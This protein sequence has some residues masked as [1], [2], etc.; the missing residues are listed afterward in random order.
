MEAGERQSAGAYAGFEGAVAG[1]TLPDVIQLNGHARFSG[2]ITVEDGSRTGAIFFRDGDIIHAEQGDAVGELAFYRIIEWPGGR[3]SLKPKVTTT[4]HTVR[5]SL[6]Y[7]LL[8]AHRLMDERRQEGG[9]VA[10]H[11][12]GT[13]RDAGE[14]GQM[15]GIPAR[16][17][18]IAGID[19][20]VV[21]GGDGS[22]VADSSFAAERLAAQALY[23]GMVGSRL[24]RAFGMGDIRSAAV[25]GREQHLLVYASRGHYLSIAVRGT[26]AIGG[27]EA[28]VRQALAPKSQE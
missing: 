3:F 7:L 17:R 9:A 11:S 5:Q 8:E 15:G 14:G 18:G 10:G 1:L 13:G 26:Y 4:S 23:L 12:A 28:E 22:P 21:L 6:N 25:E 24:G 20:A 2:C 19:Y 27:V 16:L